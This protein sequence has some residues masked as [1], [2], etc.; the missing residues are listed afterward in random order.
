[1]VRVY[2]PASCDSRGGTVAFNFLDPEGNVVDERA[3]GRDASAAGISL[4]TG[5]FCNPGA[6]EVAHGLGPGEMARWFGREDAMSFLELRDR[7]SLEH[8]RVLSAVRISVGVATNFA[9]V[10]RFLCFL[11]QFADRTAAE[12]GAPGGGS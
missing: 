10:Y 7:L 4:R 2:G 9:D 1:M 6:G 3:V 8:G 12:I 5:C 11:Q